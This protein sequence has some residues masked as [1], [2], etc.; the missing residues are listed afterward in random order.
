LTEYGTW[1]PYVG[2]DAV[3]LAVT[4]L[5]I[6]VLLTYLGTRLIGA[7]GIKRPGKTVSAFM[8]TI[9]SLSLATFLIAYVTYGIQ[10]YEQHMLAAP[11]TNPI[12]P[13]TDLCALGTFIIIVYLARNHGLK[14][15]LGSAFVGTAA[16]PMIFELPFD[17]IV[18]GRTYPPIPPAPT[19]YR[20]LFFLPLFLVEISTFSLLTLSPLTKLSKYTLFSLAGMFFVFSVWAFFGFSYPFSPISVTLNGISKILSFV[21]AITLFLKANKAEMKR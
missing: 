13:I 5:A 9:W 15:A 16:A 18:M 21:T 7:V 10:L 14:V 8:I 2:T 12:S 11:P 17:L 1:S 20:L 19:L 3:V 6:G 4:L